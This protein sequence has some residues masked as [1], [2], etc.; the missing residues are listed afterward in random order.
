MNMRTITMIAGAGCLAATL[1]SLGCAAQKNMLAEAASRGSLARWDDETGRL[2]RLYEYYPCQ[3]VYR[4]VY[5]HQWY[6]RERADRWRFGPE[7]PDDIQVNAGA[8]DLV[9][10]PTSRPF[11]FHEQ[12]AAAYPPAPELRQQLA[13]MRAEREFQQQATVSVPTDF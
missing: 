6:W 5:N 12:V 3:E 8:Y 7:L 1:F 9:D 4:S 13:A 2:Y 11:E 10:L